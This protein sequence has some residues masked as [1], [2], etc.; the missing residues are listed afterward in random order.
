MG[1]GLG[2]EWGVALGPP[3]G[4]QGHLLRLAGYMVFLSKTDVYELVWK[5]L[6]EG[7]RHLPAPP[8][9]APVGVSNV[10]T[11]FPSW[12]LGPAGAASLMLL[13]TASLHPVPAFF[14]LLGAPWHART[15][16][17]QP[18]SY[19]HALTLSGLRRHPGPPLS[20]SLSR[21]K[22]FL[23]MAPCLGLQRS[24]RQLDVAPSA[25]T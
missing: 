14:F 20:L 22:P 5:P 1:W 8:E 25:P 17:A 15:E 24:R 23:P 4:G 16:L 7:P 3:R 18:H 12:P 13:R 10:L 9:E 21:A 6:V 11:S 19:S 2:R